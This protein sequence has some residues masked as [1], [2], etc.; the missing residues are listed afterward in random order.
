MMDTLAGIRAPDFDR[1]CELGLR[2]AGPCRSRAMRWTSRRLA[3]VTPAACVG[4]DPSRWRE[5]Q[6]GFLP[7]LAADNQVAFAYPI[8]AATRT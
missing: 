5:L 4:V 7:P 2:P 8:G 1:M 3:V 6:Q